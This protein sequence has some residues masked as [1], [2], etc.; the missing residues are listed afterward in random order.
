MEATMKK[1]QSYEHQA[2]MAI[3]A[4]LYLGGFLASILVWMEGH[5]HF[6]A[7]WLLIQNALFAVWFGFCLMQDLNDR[8]YGGD[9]E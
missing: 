9:D 6:S 1:K 3:F 2:L 4:C 8:S 7:A 5:H